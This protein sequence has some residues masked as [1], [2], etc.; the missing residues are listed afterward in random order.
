M[1]HYYLCVSHTNLSLHNDTKNC[2]V[3]GGS[4]RNTRDLLVGLF[5]S[6]ACVVVVAAAAVL[7]YVALNKW[8]V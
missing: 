4:R 5:V 2:G 1:L 8:A 7:Y 6:F 3:G